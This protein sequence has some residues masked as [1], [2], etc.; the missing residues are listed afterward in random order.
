MTEEIREDQ[1][2][3]D[4]P[5]LKRIIV[6]QNKTIRHREA[7]VEKLL[8]VVAKMQRHMFGTKSETVPEEQL[9]FPFVEA[10]PV[11][12]PKERDP[13][14][15]TRPVKKNGQSG[16]GRRR[17]IPND[18]PRVVQTIELPAKE[19][20]C[21]YCGKKLTP[22]GEERSHELDL[23]PEKLF[24][25]TFVRPK[26]ACRPCQGCVKIAA[27][28]P[29]IIEKGMAGPGLL[30]AVVISKYADHLPLY[31]QEQI[32]ARHGLQLSRSTM[33]D[34]IRQICDALEPLYK[35]MR[36]DVVKS[37]TLNSDDT[38]MP[39]LE[40]G[41]GKTRQARFWT[42]RGD[43]KHRHTVYEYTPDRKQDHVEKFLKNY[44]GY[45][46]GD[47]YAG[48]KNVETGSDGEIVLVGCWAH[49]RRYFFDAKETDKERAMSAMGY[50]RRLYEIEWQADEKELHVNS[51]KELRQKY[52]LPI[53]E[54]FKQWLDAQML[55]I[56]PKSPIGEA[57]TYALGQWP[58]LV[59]Y[60]ED[61]RIPIDNNSAE[62]A[63]KPIVIGRKNYL[64]M[65]SDEGGRRA[66]ILYSLIE[67]CR[68]NDVEPWEYFKFLMQWVP[69]WP[70]NILTLSPYYRKLADARAVNTS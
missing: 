36:R 33:C 67:S 7:Q 18:F 49:A 42:Y 69:V 3:D 35:A 43:E 29:R 32:F 65:G 62:R 24:V 61:G 17:L 10:L 57:I 46:Q 30:A 38:P 22:F 68:M 20:F 26:L 11:E 31:R 59:R 2:P 14:D 48:Y 60:T 25:R 51:R 15:V 19:C 5:T 34:W 28:P 53:L 58:T 54:S 47:A 27:P 8:A 56:L 9:I 16:H 41:L 55:Q 12:E 4:I 50:I 13:S 63:I 6:E 64:F 39:V 45:L 66:A 52:S 40:P 70:K 23:E 37:E 44:E 1:L 21:D